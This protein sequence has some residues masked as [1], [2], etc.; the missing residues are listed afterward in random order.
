MRK[1]KTKPRE[2]RIFPGTLWRK[3]EHIFGEPPSTSVELREHLRR[4]ERLLMSQRGPDTVE[5]K[6]RDGKLIGQFSIGEIK[7][8]KTRSG[9]RETYTRLHPV[10]GK[11][12]EYFLVR[13]GV[14]GGEDLLSMLRSP[15]V[16][17]K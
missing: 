11:P 6:T 9:W 17:K 13:G 15:R 2:V 4:G 14:L 3:Y 12:G 1:K 5:L 16:R 8:M 10:G 7:K